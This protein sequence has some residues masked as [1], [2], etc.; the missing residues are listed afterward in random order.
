MIRPFFEV[1]FQREKKI[2]SVADGP[3]PSW[4]EELN[5][6]FRFVF[7]VQVQ[8]MISMRLRDDHHNHPRV[9]D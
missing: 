6:P 5:L 7:D 9:P 2:T 1:M 8:C 3:N 4:N